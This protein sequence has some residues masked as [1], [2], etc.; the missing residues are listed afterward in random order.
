[1]QTIRTLYIEPKKKTKKN[2]VTTCS[3]VTQFATSEDGMERYYQTTSL[4]LVKSSSTGALIA[5]TKFSISE[6]MDARYFVVE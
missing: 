2:R 3:S 1:L 4:N 5:L 6:G